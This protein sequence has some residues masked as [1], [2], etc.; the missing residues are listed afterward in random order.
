MKDKD[1]I[2]L[3]AASIHKDTLEFLDMGKDDPCY[4]K[5]RF[6]LLLK[7]NKFGDIIHKL[8]KEDK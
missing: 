1:Y 5:A 4:K 7:S 3:L 8:M 6:G 2:K